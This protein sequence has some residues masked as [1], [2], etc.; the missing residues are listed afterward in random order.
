VLLTVH[1]PFVEMDS[2]KHALMGAA[3]RL[4]MWLLIRGSAK[5]AVTTQ[6]W[7]TMIA[8]FAGRVD[9]FCAPVGS[10]FKPVNVTP[11]ERVR[12]RA[13]LGIS[14]KDVVV[15]TL[16]PTGAGKQWSSLLRIWQRLRDTHADTKLLVVGVTDDERRQLGDAADVIYAGY[17]PSDQASRLLS[18]ADVFLTLFVDGVSTRRT[19]VMAAM[20]HA[21]PVVTTGS[22]YTDKIFASSP[23]MTGAAGNDDELIAA[24]DELLRRPDVRRQHGGAAR[25]FYVRH[26]DWPVLAHRL[27][28]ELGEPA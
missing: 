16:R 8:P 24:L 19:S 4:M 25:E 6:R 18:C 22:A 14:E 3:Q 15:A 20:A 7:E 17:V 21:L 27:G 23:V 2:P 28:A 12:L 9:V 13:Q 11:D 5:I 10:P 1:E 26:F